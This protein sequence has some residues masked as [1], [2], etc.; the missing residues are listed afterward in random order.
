MAVQ[1]RFRWRA[2][3]S[4]AVAAAIAASLWNPA[5]VAQAAESTV[6]PVGDVAVSGVSPTAEKLDDNLVSRIIVKYRDDI[7][8]TSS[9]NPPGADEVTSADVVSGAPLVDELSALKLASPVDLATASR[10]AS[11]LEQDPR[12]EWAEPDAIRTAVTDSIA[13]SSISVDVTVSGLDGSATKANAF[14]YSA[15]LP[16]VST[17]SATRGPVAGGTV[18]TLSGANFA[19]TSSVKIGGTAAL[20]GA[21]TETSIVITTP[22]KSAGSYDVV[23]TT[24]EGVGTL[25]GGFTYVAPPTIA[26]VSP[27]VGAVAG[28]QTVTLTGT[29]LS[30]IS[31][32]TVGGTSVSPT[33]VDESHVTFVTPAKSAGTVGVSLV[34][35]GGSASSSNIFTYAPLPTIASLSTSTGS[36]SGGTSLTISGTNL[37]WVTDVS[38]GGAA[39]VV[40]TKTATTIVVTTPAHV[41]ESVTVTVSALNGTAA[42]S[43]A[44]TF[45]P[46][47]TVSAI[48]KSQGPLGGGTVVTLTG[49]NLSSVAGV[50]VGGT[51]AT[52]VSASSSTSLQFTMPAKTAGTYSIVVTT[53][54]GSASLS[55]AFSYLA[56]PTV[57]SLSVSS[58]FT[59]GGQSVTLTGTNLAST[60]SVTFGGTV[61]VIVSRTATTVVVTTPAR[62]AGSATVIATTPGGSSAG[63]TFSFVAPP[64]VISSIAPNAGP[65]AGGQT[66]T[67][68]G[69]GFTGA[70][71][72]GFGTG[73]T[74]V[75]VIPTVVS[76]TQLRVVTPAGTAGAKAITVVAPGGTISTTTAAGYTYVSAPTVTGVTPALGS[77]SGGTS[78]TISGA[79]LKNPSSVTVGGVAATIVSSTASTITAVTP[80]GTAG[81]RNIVVVTAG[82]TVTRT[83]GF[84]FTRGGTASTLARSMIAPQVRVGCAT[85]PAGSPLTRCFDDSDADAGASYD[86]EIVYSDAY[87]LSSATSKI[88]VDVV[89][90]ININ[91][92]TW[93]T[94]GDTD[95][96]AIFDTNGDQV[97]DVRIVAPRSAL[98]AGATASAV[99]ADW[100]ATTAS[101]VLR[102]GN[103]VA[104]SATLK[105][106][107]GAHFAFA[108]QSR[109]W[110]QF[111]G[112][113]VCLFGTGVGTVDV[114]TYLVDNL[115]P[116]GDYAPDKFSG[117]TM[118]LSSVALPIPSI[119]SLSVVSG[120]NSGGA[121]VTLTGANLAAAT[122]A[123]FGGI[124]APVTSR[125]ANSVVVTTPRTSLVGPVDVSVTTPSGV[126]T[127]AA[128]FTF[129]SATPT[130]TSVSPNVGRLAGGTT[131][132]IAGTNLGG[133]TVVMFGD[134]AATIVSS[135]PTQLVVTT[136]AEAVGF[137]AVSPSETA[138]ADGTLW[139][140]TGSYGVKSPA[141]WQRTQGSSDVVV[142]VLDTGVTAHSDLGPQVPGYDMISGKSRAND[143]DGR[144]ADPSDP[145]DWCNANSS[146]SWHGTHVEG[147]INAAINGTGSV[148]VAPN[149]KVQ[150]VRVLGR[151]GGQMSDIAAGII[152]AAGG[153]VYGV[154]SN[155]TPA[156]VI[157]LSLGGAGT[158]SYTEQYAIDFAYAQNV[159]VTIAAG[160][161]DDASANHTPGNCNHVITVAATDDAGTRASFSNFG[162]LVEISAPGVGIFSTV[163]TGVQSPGA[164]G[165]ASWNGTSMATPHVAG[166]VALMLSRNPQLTPDEVLARIQ[167]TATPFSGGVCDF[168]PT[169][170]CGSGIINA[171]LAVQ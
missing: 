137:S 37:S 77:S 152:W 62:V 109:Q 163:N 53:P 123:T 28:G 49:T 24:V 60:T 106:A 168:N 72:V 35:A 51:A 50:S 127:K 12:V 32:L 130:I 71:R 91:S 99:V 108:S 156:K 119:T 154:P 167:A 94:R 92:D 54:Y 56:A 151:C 157:S 42:K 144:D 7:V 166:V 158:C 111:S 131:V 70:T 147:T 150:P 22:A 10:V 55:N 117:N 34:T 140:L 14:T 116:G 39:A 118:D 73:T 141:A 23:V 45:A 11:E 26:S 6:A 75:N 159:V 83:A 98:V 20:L 79:N 21:V 135:S 9:M 101:W 121:T 48:N 145:G 86:G 5:F 162:S 40:S 170:T 142:A 103:G 97:Q 27:T 133:I 113:S 125:T 84:T 29:S 96:S 161:D 1:G 85:T 139:G 134:A 164:Q 13:P 18:V 115:I 114:V 81:A 61:A 41:A 129:S 90:Y 171:G 122:S 88:V 110:W 44:F 4:T 25:T 104:C 74:A 3:V 36:T 15:V 93:L 95:V 66:V 138:Y 52:A 153:S 124:V 143:G 58:G 120:L 69:S 169:K 146:S 33:V 68:T 8:I 80:A 87:V 100:N 78:I 65:R 112:D 89:P 136:P 47:P 19:N 16:V 126:A 43:S 57:A 155:P 2:V 148:G 64:P 165:Y 17:L 63:R 107:T 82:G 38:F 31:S 128:A 132:T 102:D 46:S 149:V 160:N 76:A 59:T 67:I 30:S 105:R